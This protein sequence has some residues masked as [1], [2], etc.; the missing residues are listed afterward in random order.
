MGPGTTYVLGRNVYGSIL[1]RADG[2][3]CLAEE[4]ESGINFLRHIHLSITQTGDANRT[5]HNSSGLK[6]QEKTEPI[7]IPIISCRAEL[8][9]T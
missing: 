5:T 9:Q 6:R 3:Y 4:L 2:H 1:G 7:T 8:L